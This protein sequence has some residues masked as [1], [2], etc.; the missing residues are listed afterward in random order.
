MDEIIVMS[1][2]RC[3]RITLICRYRLNLVF[4]LLRVIILPEL[5]RSFTHEALAILQKT[6]RIN[7]QVDNFMNPL[8]LS[9][10]GI[11]DTTIKTTFGTT[12]P[13]LSLYWEFLLMYVDIAISNVFHLNKHFFFSFFFLRTMGTPTMFV[14]LTRLFYSIPD[15]LRSPSSSRTCL[16][17]FKYILFLSCFGS[18]YLIRVSLDL[19][20]INF[21]LNN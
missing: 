10:K 18:S 4:I 21:L 5:N 16:D 2:R 12:K 19:L 14:V 17:H 6:K 15:T 11:F 8:K 9:T 13:L 20:S 1:C 7:W 3:S